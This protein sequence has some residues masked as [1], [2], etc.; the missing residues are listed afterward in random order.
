MGGEIFVFYQFGHVV[1]ASVDV[2]EDKERDVGSLL[3]KSR[4][5]KGCSREYVCGRYISVF[6]CVVI[7]PFY[8]FLGEDPV[9]VSSPGLEVFQTHG[10][11]SLMGLPASG[12][13]FVV[14]F[15]LFLIEA[16]SVVLGDLY[17]RKSRF[18][19]CPYY[20]YAR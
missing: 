20:G 18:V 2:I 6:Y 10:M 15:V 9:V 14:A 4:E 17:P 16:I 8:Y 1:G 7:F 5:A 13:G 12:D 11:Y 19:G 3:G